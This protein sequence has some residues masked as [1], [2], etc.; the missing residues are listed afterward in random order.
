MSLN[1]YI[2]CPNCDVTYKIPRTD[3]QLKI[4]CKNCQKIFYNFNT[5]ISPK[6]KRNKFF[7]PGLV[8][9]TI[10]A[11]IWFTTQDTKTQSPKSDKSIFSRVKSSNWVTIDYSGLV[12]NSTI[13][14][15]GKTV[16]QIIRK[17]PTYTDDLKGQVQQYLEPY[18]ILCHD[19]LLSSSQPDTLPLINILSHYPIGSEQP[20]WASLFREGHYQLYY[21]NHLIRVFIKGSNAEESFNKYQPIIRHPIRDVLESKNTS[22]KNLEVYVF[23]ND[24][25][26]TEIRLNT[27]PVI[28]D[29][30][31]L[32]LSPSRK[33]IDL[34]SLEEFLSNDVILEAVEVDH[35]N[36]LYFYGVVADQQ[37]MAGAPVS[38]SD[39]AVIYRSIFHY[40]N[41]AP[42]ISLDNH[43]DNRYAKVNFG[44][45]FENTRP[46]SV[47]LEADKLFKALS[48]GLDPNTH[49]LIK[50]RITNSVPQFLTEDERNLL[51]DLDEGHT[52]IRYWFYPDSIGTVT[53][54]SI[55]VIL[56]NQF[57]ADIE[58]MDKN[59]SPGNAVRKTINHLNNYYNQYEAADQTFQELST[60]GRIMALI[61]WLKG[62]NIEDKIELDELLSVKL[63]AF[64]TPKNTKKMLAVTATAFPS[65]SN[66]YSL[67]GFG[68]SFLNANNV[69][70]YSKVYYLSELLDKYAPTTTD[71]FFLEVAGD[72]FSNLDINE[73][74]PVEYIKLKKSLESIEREIDQKERTLNRYSS[75]DVNNFNILV[76]Q[77][78]EL[79]KQM[80]N[81][82]LQTR[83]ITSI[84]GGINL[85]PSEFKRISRN[86]NSPKL[87]EISKIKSKIKIVGKI[88]KS[89]NWIRSNPA[90]GNPIINTIPAN[91]WKSSK[92]VNGQIKYTHVSN[93]G[94]IASVIMQNSG[95]WLSN[96]NISGS[97]HAVK[98]YK[99]TN[100]L[101]ITHPSFTQEIKGSL[102]Q[103]G[104]YI[105]FHN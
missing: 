52:Q 100:Q 37:T 53:D 69:R 74:A 94:D 85:R 24:Y 86:K 19:V 64:I 68:N 47:V 89:G 42:Y 90:I 11:F 43:E 10:T 93:T 25:A 48:T 70:S 18:S 55:G 75:R 32:D 65:N 15:S 73:L 80:N 46:G 92:S 99:S 9:A 71:E 17:I 66:Q 51:E 3:Q 57:L 62:M 95:D 77:Q 12:N 28:I 105:A 56:K 87:R 91:K 82:K 21:N 20:T 97:N 101:F 4:T 61:N 38:L 8:I 98:Y 103:S 6:K 14:H 39:F 49:N 63:P 104:K 16:G 78:N 34:T 7:I 79:V 45:H 60:V 36:S 35:N 26:K 72:Y 1:E 27:V 76:N 2:S 67:A 83:G 59:V 50:T 88:A 81:M 29:M 84:G 41:N 54:G 5:E 33:S 58:R 96:I 30:N 102:S 23:S 22:I 44:G 40:G 13:T 31:S